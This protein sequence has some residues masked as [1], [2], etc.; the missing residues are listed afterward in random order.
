MSRRFAVTAELHA[1]ERHGLAIRYQRLEPRTDYYDFDA[2]AMVSMIFVGRERHWL[3]L[4]W[5]DDPLETV[6]HVFSDPETCERHRMLAEILGVP[7]SHIV[8]GPL[9]IYAH[10]T[11]SAEALPQRIL[12]LSLEQAQALDKAIEPLTDPRKRAMLLATLEAPGLT[13]RN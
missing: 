3:G 13:C 7:W 4:G 10:Q 6:E 2:E 9:E 11:Q 1:T 8:L 5:S 12:S